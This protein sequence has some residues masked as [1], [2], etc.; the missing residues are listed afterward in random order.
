MITPFGGD[1]GI[2]VYT[3]ELAR[4]LA[5]NGA[6]VDVY[7][8]SAP[9]SLNSPSSPRQFRWFPVLGSL[10]FKQRGV[11]R[12]RVEESAHALQNAA[13]VP[14]PI[15]EPSRRTNALFR[16]VKAWLLSLEL[17][18]YL[19]TRGYDVIWTQWPDMDSYGTMFWTLCKL[20]RMRIVHTVHNVLPHER[21][22]GDWAM[23]ERA[24]RCA[25]LLFV[26]SEFSRTEL[27]Q[28]FPGTS[29]KVAVGRMGVYTVYPR[30]PE[31]RERVRR[32]L[33]AAEG[34]VV[35]LFCGLI[36]PYKNI[37]AVIRALA[38][39][40]CGDVLLIVAGKE[41]GY[42]DLSCE[43]ALARS[44]KLADESGVSERVTLLPGLLRT[45]KMVELLEAADVLMLPYL[46]SY[47]SGLLMLGMTFGK[48]IVATRTGGMEEYL[49]GYSRYTLLEGADTE[50]VV[51]G[52]AAAVEDLTGRSTAPAPIAPEFQWPNIARALL[53]TMAAAFTS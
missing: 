13:S 4:S 41:A 6:K 29:G 2:A 8:G 23:C 37:D 40:R 15:R 47:G 3:R 50:H 48:H 43:N 52:I 22:P 53:E 11:L 17:V 12:R 28:E 7:A 14:S 49:R 51:R 16:D 1:D 5:E 9:S 38:D 21:F 27:L 46:K 25:D 36:R 26:H 44:N 30:R 42:P 10:L 31:A 32:T 18:L 33:G 35:L 24:Y 34:Q 39:P 20:F 19:K 45:D